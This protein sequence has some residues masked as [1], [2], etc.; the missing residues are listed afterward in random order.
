[1]HCGACAALIEETLTEREGVTSASVDL[2]SALASVE[3]DPSRLGV[4]ELT[5]AI[6]DAGYSATPVG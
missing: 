2:D 5:V 1:M 6:A 4:D 3:F